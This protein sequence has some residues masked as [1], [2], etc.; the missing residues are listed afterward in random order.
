MENYFIVGDKFRKFSEN[1]NTISISEFEKRIFK[2]QSYKIQ[3]FY[4]F[5]QGVSY[6]RINRIY[7]KSNE[8]KKRGII[9]GIK[10]IDKSAKYLV[11]KH[12]SANSMIGFPSKLSDTHYQAE[13]HIDDRCSE[14][15][16]HVTGQH[17]SGMLLVEACRQMFLAVTEQYYL[18]D[19]DNDFYFVIKRNSAEYK[20][21]VFPVEITIDYKVI[22][23]E[24]MKPGMLKFHVSMDVIQYNKI[25]TTVEYEFVT[26]DQTL[27][28]EKEA[29]IAK[30]VLKSACLMKSKAME[31][32]NAMG[33][34][35]SVILTAREKE[36]S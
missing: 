4:Y 28:A 1:E 25:C 3:R 19:Y 16:D 36:L 7:K 34:N 11:H 9:V 31:S 26:Y 33:V 17:I 30:E 29:A 13:V 23:Y 10:E 20:K 12:N 2:G 8:L 21:F 5:G 15:E 6:E 35:K 18:K 24:V 32:M 14:L 22:N 27:I